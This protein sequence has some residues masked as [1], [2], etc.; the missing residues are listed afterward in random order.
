M[1]GGILSGV[2]GNRADL[3]VV[4]DPVKGREEAESETIRKKTR[5]AFDD[6]LQTRLKPGGRT[7]IIQTRWHADD[8]LAASCRRIGVAKAV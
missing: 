4:D 1:A 7:I 6:D 2:T 3:L 5:E 8:Q